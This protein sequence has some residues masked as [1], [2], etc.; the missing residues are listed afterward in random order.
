MVLNRQKVDV[1]DD[2]L[3]WNEDVVNLNGT[4]VN[5]VDFCQLGTRRPD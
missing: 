1:G 5:T 4:Q 3:I 2:E